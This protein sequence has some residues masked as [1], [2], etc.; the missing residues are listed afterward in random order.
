MI[1]MTLILPIGLCLVACSTPRLSSNTER[2]ACIASCNNAWRSCS[3]SEA[4]AKVL[5]E[6]SA[7][8]EI[9][10]R[11]CSNKYHPIFR[12]RSCDVDRSYCSAR[13]EGKY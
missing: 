8:H 7:T 12:E 11:S 9:D 1:R 10:R 2:S 4:K 3:N 5:C 13:C 6:Q